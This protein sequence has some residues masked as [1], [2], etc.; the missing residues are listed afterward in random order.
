MSSNS[1]IPIRNSISTRLLKVVFS[2]YLVIAVGVTIGH[3]ILEY[4]YQKDNIRQDLED[5]QKTFEQSIALDLWN[6]NQKSLSSTLNGMLKIPAI[7]GVKIQNS[8]ELDVAMGGIINSNN[9]IGD[10]GQ[11]VDLLGLNKETLMIQTNKTYELELFTHEFPIIYTY[12]NETRMMGNATLYSSTSIVFR[13]VKLGFMLLVINAFLKTAALGVIFLWFSNLFIQKPL[14][15]L[16]ADTKKI[17]LKNLDTFRVKIDTPGE[18]ELTVIENSFNTMIGNLHQSITEQ[19]HSEN[20]LN[21]Y[22]QRLSLHIE[23]TPL[24]VIEFDKAFKI[25]QWNTAAEKIFGFSKSEA[26]GKFAVDL[27]LNEKVQ[28]QIQPIMDNLLIGKGGVK[29]INENITKEGKT[30]ICEWHNTTLFDEKNSVIGVASLVLDITDREKFEQEKKNLEIQLQQSQKMEAIGTLAGGVAHDFNNILGIILG[31]SELLNNDLDLDAASKRKF[32]Q[33]ISAGNRA[34]GLV[35]QILAF[36]RQNSEEFIQIQP[37]LI[38]NEALKMLR[39]SIPTT[40]K[41]ESNIPKS[42]SILGD[43]TQFHQIIMNLCTNAYHAMKETGGTLKVTLET[44]ILDENDIKI[45]SMKL[46]PGT[47]VNLEISDTGHGIDKPTQEKI[48]DPYFTTK[49]VGEGTGLGLSVVHGIV[50]NF[51]GNI[52]IYSE[53]E[54]GTTFKVYLP[55]IN[56]DTETVIIKSKKTYPTGNEHILVVDDERPIV[57]MEKLMLEGLGYTI[58]ESVSSIEAISLFK[59]QSNTIDL[60]ITDVTMPDLNGIELLQKIRSIKPDLPMILCSGFSELIDD[61]KTTYLNKVRYLKKPILKKDFAL[62]IRDLLDMDTTSVNP[63]N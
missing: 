23:N 29:S 63:S 22:A 56:N 37:D 1:R 33:I 4:R 57:E 26:I 15:A 60:V 61:E 51:K 19:K 18:N 41:I 14:S 28:I 30:I 32:D 52:S 43:P 45:L 46:S 50:K 2:L 12:Q 21:E 24:G 8:S 10:M 44:I 16:A 54:M 36:S 35:R 5:I 9:M 27:I 59:E 7:V 6:M 25:T 47:Y 42:G 58:T 49:K 53:P 40:I 11:H 17:T 3:M 62:T 38:I 39:A 34:S 48:F 13:R 31:Y 55:H 20:E